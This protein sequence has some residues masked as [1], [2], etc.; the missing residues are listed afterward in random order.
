MPKRKKSFL[1]KIKKAHTKAKKKTGRTT[2]SRKRKTTTR[3]RRKP[4]WRET[5][6]VGNQRLKLFSVTNSKERASRIAKEA[7]QDRWKV[8]VS[9]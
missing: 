6:K 2:P 5:R 8:V 3:K 7:R 1:S 9:S 4:A